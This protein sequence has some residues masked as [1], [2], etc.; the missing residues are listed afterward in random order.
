M[1]AR[2]I[3]LVSAGSNRRDR[4]PSLG[5]TTLNNFSR[6]KSVNAWP[7]DDMGLGIL[8]QSIRAVSNKEL[9]LWV[10]DGLAYI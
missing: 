8:S 4:L 3:N 10:L 5:L 6:S 1:W 9:G 2:A 7:W